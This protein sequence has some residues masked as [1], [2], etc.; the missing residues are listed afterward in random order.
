MPAP[1]RTAPPTAS[2]AAPV[3]AVD[4]AATPTTPRRY[5]SLSGRGVGSR[6]ATSCASRAATSAVGRYG[7][8]PMSTTSTT[9]AYPAPGAT[10]KPGLPVPNVTVTSART[11][12]PSTRPVS[13]STPLGTSTDTTA[14]PPPA[15]AA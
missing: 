3:Y 13:A 7:P 9:P 15:A 14:A 6:A 4:P 11:A 2:T 1:P 10:S 8:S 5:L 12:T